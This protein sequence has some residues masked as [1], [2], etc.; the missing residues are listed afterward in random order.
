MNKT[1]VIV[2]GLIITASV[3]TR[4]QGPLQLTIRAGTEIGES[5]D[6]FRVGDSI[7]ITLTM[8]NTS[9][10]PQNVCLSSNL[11]QNL[12]R[13]TKD[14]QLIPIMKWTSSVRRIAKHDETCKDINLPQKVG[15]DPKAQK[16]ID[17]FVLVDSNVS[18]G[19]ESWYDSLLPG[20]YELSIQRRLDCCDGPT[21]ESNKI[22]FTVMP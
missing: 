1:I 3:Q 5:K 4:A 8:T 2:I 6:R 13:L 16:D 12:P 22:T 18:T 14:G 21:V 17:W 19:A 9:A 20:K 7:L 11:Y 10:D 15:L